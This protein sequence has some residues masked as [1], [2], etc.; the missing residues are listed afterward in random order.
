[1]SETVWCP[2]PQCGF[3]GTENDVNAHRVDNH[4]DERQQGSNLRERPRD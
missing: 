3:S 1:M 2:Y 4:Q